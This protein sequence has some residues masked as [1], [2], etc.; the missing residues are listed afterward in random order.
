MILHNRAIS[1]F[2]FQAGPYDI[3]SLGVALYHL[4]T[5]RYPFVE[6]VRDDPLYSLFIEDPDEFLSEETYP[7][8]IEGLDHQ[9][10]YDFMS[11]V[12]ECFKEIPD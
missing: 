12:V 9:T 1:E 8:L 11:L 3:F 6:A 10:V 4:L 2:D 7:H 5:L